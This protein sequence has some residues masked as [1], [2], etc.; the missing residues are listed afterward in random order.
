MLLSDKSALVISVLSNDN[1]EVVYSRSHGDNGAD[2][3]GDKGRE[4]SEAG[5]R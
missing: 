5:C 4:P 2:S 3:G 1:E